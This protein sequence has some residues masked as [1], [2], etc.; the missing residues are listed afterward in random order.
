M[1]QSVVPDAPPPEPDAPQQVSFVLDPDGDHVW[2]WHRCNHG[3]IRDDGRVTGGIDVVETEQHLLPNGPWTIVSRDPLHIEPS[4]LCGA[5][6]FHGFIRS[7]RWE[8]A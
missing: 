1:V 4:I 8:P 6:G 7:G 5:C 2:F 3:G